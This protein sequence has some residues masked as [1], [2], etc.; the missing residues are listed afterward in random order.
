MCIGHKF[1]MEEAQLTLIS[2]YRNFRFALDDTKMTPLGK[3]LE[4]AAGVVLKPKH[5]IWV[6]VEP[7]TL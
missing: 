6:K 7:R 4:I 3:E 2:L 5:G 1:A